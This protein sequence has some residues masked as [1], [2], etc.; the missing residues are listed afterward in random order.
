MRKVFRIKPTL[1]KRRGVIKELGDSSYHPGI[2]NYM[3]PVA[4]SRIN[5]GV[6]R[7]FTFNFAGSLDQ[8]IVGKEFRFVEAYARK[9]SGFPPK[10][11]RI[12]MP[13]FQLMYVIMSDEDI[14][15]KTKRFE[16]INP[17]ANIHNNRVPVHAVVEIY[18]EIYGIPSDE[19]LFDRMMRVHKEHG[20]GSDFISNLDETTLEWWI[21]DSIEEPYAYSCNKYK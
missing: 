21:G 2:N 19:E 4:Y 20:Y 5:R 6:E 7:D 17:L 15:D 13:Y 9:V 3:T 11:E 18:R 12:D 10:L 16:S 8:D 1:S 14:L